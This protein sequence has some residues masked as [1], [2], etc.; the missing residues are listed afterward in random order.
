MMNNHRKIV[1]PPEC[2]FAIWFMNDFSE[3]RE[4]EGYNESW[5]DD[6]I[7]AISSA[8]KIETWSLDFEELRRFL[9]D[10]SPESYSEAV[11]LVYTFYGVSGSGIEPSV[12]GDKNNFYIDYI[13]EIDMLFGNCKFVHIIRDGRDVA[14]SYRKINRKRIDSEYAPRLPYDISNIA[15]EWYKNIRSIKEQC[16]EIGFDRVYEVKYEDLVV[17]PENELRKICKFIG[18]KYDERMLNYYLKNRNEEQEPREFLKWKQKTLD[19]PSDDRVG[20]YKN[21][22]SKD[23]KEKFNSIAISILKRYDYI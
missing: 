9:Y 13:C 11:S 12:W 15:E 5:I 1:V 18:E 17:N 4:E 2:G 3:W 7:K 8:R 21:E 19:P 6:F 22:L 16:R 20:V 14:C 10:R 23:Q